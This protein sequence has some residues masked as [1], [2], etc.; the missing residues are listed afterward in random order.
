MT[1]V[2]DLFSEIP[3]PKNMLREMSKNPCF[4]GPFDRKQR[5]RVGTLLQSE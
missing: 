1:L 3:A 5:K 2:A 4:K